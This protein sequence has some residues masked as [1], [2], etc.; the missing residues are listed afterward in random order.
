ME[1]RQMKFYRCSIKGDVTSDACYKCY[2]SQKNK[3]AASR[4]LCKQEHVI[5]SPEE[6]GC[7]SM[8]SEGTVPSNV[9]EL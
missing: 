4:V 5:K 2:V 8:S 3:L 9:F 6:S 7:S 1:S